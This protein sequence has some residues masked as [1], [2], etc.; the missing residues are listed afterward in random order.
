VKG[1]GN[2]F[3]DRC[4]EA[5]LEELSAHG[6]RKLAAQRCA[7]AGATE[8]QLMALFGW[9]NPQQAAVYTKRASRARLE[10]AAVA[11]LEARNSNKEVQAI[12]AIAEHDG[13]KSAP[14]FP[15]VASGG[16]IRAKTP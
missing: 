5:G 12:P 7:E 6:L 11:F 16:S 4:R 1:F 2:W 13:N 8:H 15:A 3:K 14:L 9:A 10:A